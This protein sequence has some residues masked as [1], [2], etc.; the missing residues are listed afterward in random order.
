[1][2]TITHDWLISHNACARGMRW[3]GHYCPSGKAIITPEFLHAL[4]KED[5]SWVQWL[6]QRLLSPPT[7][8]EYLASV[9][10]LRDEADLTYDA[11]VS[12]C[13]MTDDGFFTHEYEAAHEQ[14][15]NEYLAARVEIEFR[16]LCLDD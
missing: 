12:K 3:F 7:W 1:M 16:A 6:A 2:H 11:M 8:A 14:L 15:W 9:S 10:K 5:P 4:A 13:R